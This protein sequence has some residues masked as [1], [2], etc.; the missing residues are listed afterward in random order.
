MGKYE[1]LAKDIIKNVGGTENIKGVT[2]CV[3]RLRFALRDEAKAQDEILKNMDGVV[4]VMHSAG[5]YQVVIGNHVPEVY[6]DVCG[7]ADLKKETVTEKKKVS[8][9]EYMLDLLTSIFMP[10]IGV[11]CACGMIKGMDAILQFLGLYGAGSGIATLISAIGDCVFYFFPVIIGFNAAKK[12]GLSQYLGLLIGAALCYPTINGVDLEIFGLTYNVSYTSTVLPVILTVAVA[13]PLERFLKK[14]IPDVVKN[15]LVPMLVLL[16]STIL[17]YMIIG[18]VANGI[19]NILSNFFLSV[20]NISPL[21]AGVLVGGLWQV[22]VIF[23]VHMA[24]IVLAIMNLSQGIPDPILATQVFV[25][26][27]QAAVVFAIWLK[28]KNRKLKDIAFPAFVSGIFGVTEPAIYG[29]TLPR[30]NM[31]IISC[32]GGAVSGGFAGVMGLKYYNMAGMGIFEI[33]ALFPPEGV[34]EVLI[35]S[36]IASAIAVVVSFIP[37]FLLYKDETPKEEE[38]GQESTQE[39]LVKKETIYAPLK[40]EVK[41]LAQCRDD[42]FAQGALGKGV[43]LL[44]GEGKVFAPFDGTLTTLFPTKHALGLI[45]NSGCEVLIHIGMNTVQLDG[46]YFEAHAAQGD[47]VRKGELLLSFDMDEIKAAG[48]SLETPVLITNSGDYVDYIE[49]RK[50]QVNSQD[51]LL[52][53]II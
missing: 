38:S 18:P 10:S 37:A 23:G 11:L 2:H 51:E 22:M 43:L 31:F 3:T 9:K 21:L 4:T 32:I 39:K 45:S 33:P 34:G 50:E 36:V 41:P 16:I 5:Q 14:V 47:R 7:L 6:A 42:A 48:Y 53:V 25:A 29:V 12:F 49:T 1:Q 8:V 20:Y 15:F 19:S 44:P 17:G 40:G 26:F 27:S 28:T 24:L 30:M 52:T 13:A 46:K 35:L